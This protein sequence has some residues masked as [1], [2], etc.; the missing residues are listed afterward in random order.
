MAGKQLLLVH[1]NIEIKG[2]VQKILNEIRSENHEIAP[3]CW[4]STQEEAE[5]NYLNL[6]SYDLVIIYLYLPKTRE[7]VQEPSEQTGLRLALKHHDRTSNESIILIS[8]YQNETLLTVCEQLQL[9]LVLEGTNFEIQLKDEILACLDST[10]EVES[11]QRF[12]LEIEL[13][14]DTP[15]R[16]HWQLRGINCAVNADGWLSVDT[17]VLS[18]LVQ[19]S[20]EELTALIE[21]E[22]VRATND[23]VW[24]RVL[25]EIGNQLTEQIFSNNLELLK[26]FNQLIGRVGSIENARICFRVDEKSYPIA[27]EALTEK[28]EEFWMLQAPIFR[29]LR[30]RNSSTLIASQRYALFGSQKNR[31]SAINCLIIQA[32]ATGSVQGLENVHLQKLE[33]VDTEAQWLE[34]YLLEHKEEFHIGDVCRLSIDSI[35]AE[36]SFKDV[37]K[38]ILFGFRKCLFIINGSIGVDLFP[39]AWFGASLS[40]MVINKVFPCW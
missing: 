31:K 16:C 28:D 35:P 7:V 34:K 10:H 22:K 20:T 4:A 1:P 11:E 23:H 12:D 15:A 26:K 21:M 8:P 18:K 32:N 29:R 14:L 39:L 9:P 25:Q 27:L 2:V 33:N 37:V 36:G 17:N 38:Q 40:T 30:L 13:D 19:K 24:Q 3:L 6:Q 5:E